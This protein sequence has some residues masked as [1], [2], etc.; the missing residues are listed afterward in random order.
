MA[1]DAPAIPRVEETGLERDD[2]TSAAEE[3]GIDGFESLDDQQLFEQIGLQLG[4]ISEDQL[5]EAAEQA[6]ETAGGAADEAQDTAEDVQETAEDTAEQA[7]DA[8][9][10]A[11]DEA[12]DTAED[13][14][15]KGQET[16][17]GAA[18]T[19]ED[20]AEDAQA[21]GEDTAEDAQETAEETAEETQESAEGA[22][23]EA[24]D[25]AEDSAEQAEGAAEGAADE[26]E[27]TAEETQD[28]AE[29]SA[30]QAE[31]SAEGAAEEAEDTAETAEDTSDEDEE[32]EG[33]PDEY[34]PEDDPR[35]G[36][37]TVLDL[38]LGPVALDL[39]GL[40]VH[41]NRIHAAIVANPAPNYA[42]LGKLLAP[43]GS[44]T[45]SLGL[46]KVTDTVTD[47]V[48]STLD[49]L[50]SPGGEDEEGEDDES[51]DGGSV[52]S[53]MAEPFVAAARLIKN[54]VTNSKDAAG[55]AKEAGKSGA[56]AVKNV[57]SGNTMRA[58][59]DGRN[60]VSH[61]T[62]AAKRTAALAEDR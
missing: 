6:Q 17:E 9:E 24:Q 2:L 19:A 33:R 56:G 57:A 32:E 58:M 3:L 60:A 1:T 8:A 11:A 34:R 42:I 46:D 47:A 26:A 39:L 35:P 16:A 31:E 55:E 44:V 52:L 25:T 43:L 40:E 13:V 14:I 51:E 62:K 10:G 61:A 4:E 18:D 54:L 20:V 15:G 53:T 50:P 59:K 28:T 36:I 5:S 38:E 23:E 45:S 48:D 41:L 30:E 12:Q 29:D 49:V 27:D 21:T 7:E 37:A 22:A